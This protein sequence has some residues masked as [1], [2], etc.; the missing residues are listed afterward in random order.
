MIACWY[1]MYIQRF[2]EEKKKKKVTCNHR[3]NHTHFSLQHYRLKKQTYHKNLF[4]AT[5]QYPLS[6][7]MI[8][9]HLS[10]YI[11]VGTNLAIANASESSV[12]VDEE[13]KKLEVLEEELNGVGTT[14][15]MA[16]GDF[17]LEV[18]SQI[19]DDNPDLYCS[20]FQPSPS[21]NAPIDPSSPG[22]HIWP[23]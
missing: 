12:F 1:K 13:G 17:S 16:S 22:K 3:P 23:K 21:P 6:T 11:L 19:L 4:G 14:P 9:R 8:F 15:G 18:S 5:L 7:M 2:G 20:P 10:A